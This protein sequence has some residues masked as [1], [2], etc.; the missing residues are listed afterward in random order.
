MNVFNYCNLYIIMTNTT[1][2]V[3]PL[4]LT[5]GFSEL[6]LTDLFSYNMTRNMYCVYYS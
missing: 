4:S 5:N 1:I 6:K 2:P 3:Y